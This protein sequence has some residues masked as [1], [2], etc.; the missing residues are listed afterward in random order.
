[1]R[2]A[3]GVSATLNV[4]AFTAE[5]TRTLHLMGTHGEISGHLE[6]NEI[7]VIDFRTDDVTTIR[8]T[9]VEDSGHSGGDDRLMAEF[10]G[11]QIQRRGRSQVNV[12]LTSLEESLDSHFMAFAAER[13][14]RTGTMVRL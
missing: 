10:L 4:S 11:R 8:L 12:A 14:R 3:N 13:S 2:F 9:T 6:N 5:N 7:T 1:M